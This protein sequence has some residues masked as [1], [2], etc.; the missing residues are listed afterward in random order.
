MPPKARPADTSAGHVSY[1]DGVRAVAAT[2]VVL[3]H[4]YLSAYPSWP[5]NGGPAALAWLLYGHLAVALF[6]IVSGVSLTLAP[7]RNGLRLSSTRVYL[8]RRAWR[9]IPAYWAA[10]VVSVAVAVLIDNPVSGRSV[11]VHALLVQDVFA[12]RPINGAFWSIAV[13]WQI[14][15]LF[16]LVLLALRRTRIVPVVAAALAAGVVAHLLGVTVVPLAVLDH[17]SPAFFGL[18]VLGVACVVATGGGSAGHAWP[19]SLTWVALPVAAA[20][21]L[22]LLVVLGVPRYA[23][24]LFWVDIVVGGVFALALGSMLAGGLPRLRRLLSRRIFVFPGSFSYSIYLVHAPLIALL[25]HFIAKPLGLHRGRLLLFLMTVGLPVIFAASYAFYRTAER[26][27]L[28][29]RSFADIRAAV[30]DGRGACGHRPGFPCP[31]L[32]SSKQSGPGHDYP[33]GC[34]AARRTPRR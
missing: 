16:P 20:A 3:H 15:F 14:Y 6:I 31:E 30:W 12:N 21:A 10:I 9:I 8:R 11:L 7:V 17:V 23:A 29:H 28:T 13:E 27:F 32:A 24:N 34:R 1:L 18:F 26:P 33:P 5:R 22:V 19:R 25:V 4:S 2:F